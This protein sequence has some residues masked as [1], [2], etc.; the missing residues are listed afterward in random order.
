MND[1]AQ[2]ITVAESKMTPAPARQTQG[3]D[4]LSVIERI[5]TSPNFNIEALN[6]VVALRERIQASEAKAAFDRDLAAMQPQLPTIDS[7]GVITVY[8]K[9]D[10]EKLGG[11]RPTDTPQQKTPYALMAD[12]N[13]AVRPALAE[14]GFALSF[15]VGEDNGKIKVTGI[16]SHREGHR[17]ETSLVLQHDST[18]SKN[19]V[20]AV[21]SSLSYGRR[22]AT[23]MLLNISS[24]SPQDMDD[25]GRAAGKSAEVETIDVVE[26]AYVRQLLTD[27]KSDEAKFLAAFKIGAVEDLTPSAFKHAIDI[28]NRKRANGAK[29]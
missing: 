16:L 8:S 1:H 17:E 19:S 20:Q 24:R 2:E 26:A 29:P 4:M 22:Y 7:R 12:I 18:G 23:L 15:R 14:H 25:D 21:G 3:A 11:P 10:R 27:T 6:A 13:D 9:G 28:L 5:A